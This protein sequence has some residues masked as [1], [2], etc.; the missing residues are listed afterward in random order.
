MSGAKI[1]LLCEDS[2]TN[3]FV[4]RFLKRRNFSNRDIQTLPLSAGQGSGEQR[5][6]AQYPNQLK[7]I[8]AKRDAYLIVVI[9]ADTHTTSQRRDQLDDVCRQQN[10]PARTDEDSVILVIPKR[11]IET[12]FEYLNGSVVDEETRYPKLKRERDCAEPARELYEMRHRKQKLRK[13]A[14]PS[15]VETCKEYEILQK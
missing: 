15:L 7:A 10:V 11:N 5:V 8:R 4:R 1:V 12:W 14:P 6:R 2:Q 9:D 13:P 3:S